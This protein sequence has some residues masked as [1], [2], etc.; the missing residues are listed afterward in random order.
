MARICPYCNTSNRDTAGFCSNCGQPL[1]PSEL[2]RDA[3]GAI[4]PGTV[5]ENRYK[6]EKVLGSGG[7]GIVYLARHIHINKLFAIKE[8]LPDPA[9]SLK[10]QIKQFELEAQLLAQLNHPQLVEVTDYFTGP[11]GALFLV[12]KFI[13]GE[14]LEERL[15][16]AGSPL[17]ERQ[18]VEWARQVCAVLDYMHNWVNPDTG[19]PTAIIHRDVKPDNLKLRPDGKIMLI[20]LGIAKVKQPGRGT[21]VAARAFSPGY[22][23]P[24][25]YGRGTDERSDVYAL[26]A[27]MYHLLTG[28]VP[29]AA[30][31]ITSGMVQLIPPRRINPALSPQ[32]ESVILKAMAININNRYQSAA[33]TR[34]ALLTPTRRRWWRWL[35]LVLSISALSIAVVVAW[36]LLPPRYDSATG[37]IF[38]ADDR[39]LW[40]RDSLLVSVPAS[41]S[42]PTLVM[43]GRGGAIQ[44][45][46]QDG[47]GQ[48]WVGLAGDGLDYQQGDEWTRYVFEGGTQANT[49]Q[50]IIS[51]RSKGVWIGTRE[52]A[53]HFD[54][55][56]WS[57]YTSDDGLSGN[58]VRAITVAHDDA[59][60]FGTW[61][62]GLTSWQEDRVVTYRFGDNEKWN[63]I[64]ALQTLGK[65][66]WVG[67][68]AGLVQFHPGAQE[69]HYTQAEGLAGD[70]VT[71]LATDPDGRLWVGTWGG[72]VSTFDQS[73]IASTVFKPKKSNYVVDLAVG[74]S[75][76]WVMSPAGIVV[77]DLKT[78]VWTPY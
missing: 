11:A 45:V 23:P 73:R 38:W 62:D 72:G 33:E 66:L 27:T 32:V 25:Q 51:D 68:Q 69:M 76:V 67:T 29:P 2:S 13:P 14:T 30:G 1:P 34:Q 49:M 65:D 64:T 47:R 48:L 19:Q 75:K 5:L 8:L 70:K 40:A 24:E 77:F 42:R 63:R 7:F 60:W 6:I 28:Q 53:V 74:G 21:T 43:K 71:G 55:E 50:A 36:F 52:G 35:T 61:G 20:D 59:V 54:G 18:V 58:D 22:S 16:D 46:G 12:M 4:L 39:L 57:F 78:E 44:S 9:F 3:D 41:A 26:G 31:D 10:G 17:P 37:D 15:T 56:G